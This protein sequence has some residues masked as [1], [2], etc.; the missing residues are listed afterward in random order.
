MRPKIRAKAG[1][2]T[3]GIRISDANEK[4]SHVMSA[5]SLF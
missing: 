3:S 5:V 4:Q 2:K 1:S